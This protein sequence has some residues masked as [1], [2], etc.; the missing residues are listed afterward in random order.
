MPLVTGVYTGSWGIAGMTVSN[1]RLLRE[2][3]STP[4]TWTVRQ[5]K[6]RLY[7]HVA[8]YPEADPAH[9]VVSVRDNPEW[10]R[11][12][13]PPRNSW[14]EQV[15]RSCREILGMGR[16]PA[17]RLALRDPPVWR[18]RVGEAT[19]I[20]TYIYKILCVVLSSGSDRSNQSNQTRHGDTLVL[21]GSKSGYSI[22][23]PS[24]GGK[25]R[26]KSEEPKRNSA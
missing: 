17:W 20:F 3:D 6:I 18:R 10:R 23:L 8:R 9:R 15:D 14:L 1:Q 21:G 16:W 19:Y 12:R 13:G 2:T 24:F 5:R 11:P 4:V 7:G 22:R 26:K 25:K